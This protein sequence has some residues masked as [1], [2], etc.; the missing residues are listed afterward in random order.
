MRAIIAAVA[1]AAALAGPARAKVIA[2]CGPLTGYSYFFPHELRKESG[3]QDGRVGSI[4]VF[5][6]SGD[7]LDLII[8]GK[9]VSGEGTWTRSASD[10]GAPV[11]NVGGKP[12]EIMHILVAWGPATEIYSLDL[13]GKTLAL[14]SHKTGL[15]HLMHA[16]VGPCE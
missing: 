14:T 4:N 9:S 11:L 6:K 16:M 12:G 3:W 8:T 13:K 10:Y 15:L 5:V 1:V 2:S 7:K